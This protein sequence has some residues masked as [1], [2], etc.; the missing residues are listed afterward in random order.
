MK[1]LLRTRM[2]LRW[3][4][5]ARIADYRM[6]VNRSNLHVTPHSVHL[7]EIRRKSPPKQ[8]KYFIGIPRNTQVV[9]STTL[10]LFSPFL[11]DF[12]SNKLQSIHHDNIIGYYKHREK[13]IIPRTYISASFSHAAL[14][15]KLYTHT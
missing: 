7:I 1:R 11:E 15:R 5:I 8:K 6:I 2:T 4:I 13:K 10:P 12:C 9:T 3:L 14:N